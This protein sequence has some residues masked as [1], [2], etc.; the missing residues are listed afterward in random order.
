[1]C[2]IFRR[3]QFDEYDRQAIA[4]SAARSDN[5][6]NFVW[7]LDG[8]NDDY[9]RATPAAAAKYN[10]TRVLSH[11]LAHSRPYHYPLRK[12][13]K[14][15]LVNDNQDCVRMLSPHC[16]PFNA[17]V[18]AAACGSIQS[19]DI[20]IADGHALCESACAA[21]ASW[22]R[23]EVLRH[24][25]SHGCPWDARTCTEAMRCRRPDIVAY[26]RAQGCP[27][28]VQSCAAAAAATGQR[29][30][31]DDLISAGQF[32]DASTCA[33]ASRNGNLDLVKYLHENGCPMDRRVVANAITKGHLDML[34]YAR[35]NG[36][37]WPPCALDGAALA[38]CRVDSTVRLYAERHYFEDTF[39]AG[40]IGRKQCIAYAVANGCPCEGYIM[41]V[42]ARTGDLPRM[43]RLYQI[44]YSWSAYVTSIA[45]AAGRNDMVIYAH[46]HGCP[47]DERTVEAACRRGA[48]N[49]LRYVLANG[50]PYDEAKALAAAKEGGQWPCARLLTW[51]ALPGFESITGHTSTTTG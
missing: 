43:K 2:R 41:E 27:Y 15:A 31:L 42:L 14:R 11:I 28:D 34:M 22:G 23:F 25:R 45:A 47:W 29:D 35:E 37:A 1:M 49:I 39:D 26:A 10:A 12:A 4:R 50:C 24:L 38:L 7:V 5:V 9:I 51:A 17:V 3:A 32:I 19:I 36:C 33:A 18:V 46:A 48:R 13:M 44:G 30:F 6:T 8:I 40:D 20:L 21:A 16:K